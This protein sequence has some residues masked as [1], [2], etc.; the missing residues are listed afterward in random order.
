MARILVI[1]DSPTVVHFVRLAL[2]ADGHDV[3]A[4]DSFIQL[5]A[6]VRDDPPD[7]VLLDLNIPALSGLS[8]GGLVRKYEQGKTRIVIYSSRP[9][10]ELRQAARE[11]KAVAVLRKSSNTAELRSVVKDALMAQPATHP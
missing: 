5:A 10:E 2:A 1:D 7:L 3:K 4:L 9:V 11:L 6:I 8:M